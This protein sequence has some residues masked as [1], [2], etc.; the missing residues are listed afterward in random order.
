MIGKPP[1]KFVAFTVPSTSNFCE[2]I[3]LPRPTLPSSSI[4]TTCD[5]PSYNLTKSAVPLWVTATPT[6][7]ILFAPTSILST[8]IKF[9]SNVVVVPFTVKSPPR[10]KLPLI[11]PFPFTSNPVQ[12]TT[13][14]LI[15]PLPPL[16]DDAVNIPLIFAFPITSNAYFGCKLPIPTRLFASSR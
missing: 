5:V 8:P 4:V 6:K 9:V 3:A 15:P 12:V 16:N 7:V 1:T 10:T 11:S 2:G 13:P 14:A